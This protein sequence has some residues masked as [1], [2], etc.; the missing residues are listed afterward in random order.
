MFMMKKLETV[1]RVHTHTHT[2]THTHSSIKRT[3]VKYPEKRMRLN[4]SR[5]I[6]KVCVYNYEV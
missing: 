3:Y 4:L 2:H 6:D 1:A 5:K